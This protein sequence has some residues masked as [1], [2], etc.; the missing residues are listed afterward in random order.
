MAS[1]RG[2]FNYLCTPPGKW[3]RYPVPIEV[4]NHWWPW[5]ESSFSPW[6]FPA[7]T[8]WNEDRMTSHFP[9][10]KKATNFARKSS[11]SSNRQRLDHWL[12][13]WNEMNLTDASTLNYASH[14]AHKRLQKYAPYCSANFQ[15]QKSELWTVTFYCFRSGQRWSSF[16]RKCLFLT[17]KEPPK[18]EQ[19]MIVDA[20][21]CYNW[22]ITQPKSHSSY[23]KIEEEKSFKYRLVGSPRN[24]VAVYTVVA[25]KR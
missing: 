7:K 6:T 1:S 23:S 15:S 22:F 3:Y 9:A 25:V 19:S 10:K 12:F 13:S 21:C 2:K 20:R 8:H 24:T 18:C 4:S 11:N 14:A 16:R 5:K 17:A